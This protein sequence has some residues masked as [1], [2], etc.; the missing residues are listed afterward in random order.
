M[1]ENVTEKIT[2][3]VETD[4]VLEILSKEIY[5]SP[6]ALLRENLQNAYDAVLMRSTV[7]GTDLRQHVIE[8]RVEPLLLTISDDGIGMTESVL[9][10]NFWKA[11]SSGKRTELAKRSGVIGTFGIGAMANFGV[12]T[13][14]TV[15]TRSIESNTT[16]VSVAERSK[17][18]IAK[19]C[20]DLKRLKDDRT[21]GTT[22]IAELDPS[23]PLQEKAA[24]SY[25][26][27]YVGYVP[28]KVLLNGDLISQQ[29]Y[30]EKF[31]DKQPYENISKKDIVAGAYEA[32]VEIYLNTNAQVLAHVTNL[33]IQGS[34]VLGD[35]MLA[36]NGGQ[37]LGLRNYFGLSP[38]PVGGFYQLGGIAN[39]TILQPT[40][41]R[42][43]ISRES[44]EHISTI[45]SMIERAMSE[46]LAELDAADRNPAFLQYIASSGRTDL[47]KRVTIEVLPGNNNVALDQITQF[48]KGRKL[49]Y[50]TGRDQTIL[51]TFAH[52]ESWLLHVSQNNPRKQVQL[53]YIRNVL[54]IEEVPDK[55]T[56]IRKFKATELSLEEASLLARIAATLSDDYLLPNVDISFAEISHGVAVL[57]SKNGDSVEIDLARNSATVAPVLE[58]YR[59]AY[60]VFGGFVKDF[61]RNHL[62]QRISKFVPSSTREGAEAL[63]KLL[64]RNREL[65]RYEESELGDLEPLLGD[66]LSGD[67]SLAQVLVAARSTIRPQTQ[68]VSPKQVG[69]FEQAIPDVVNSPD[70]PEPQ[71]AQEFEPAPPILRTDISCDLKILLTNGKHAQLN[72]FELFLG[73]SD[74]LFKREGDFFRY[75]HT[76]KVIWAGHRVIYIFSAAEGAVTLYYDIELSEPIDHETASGGMF[77][78]T[79][80]ITKNRIFIPVPPPLDSVFRI[81]EG[82][83]EFFVRFD[84]L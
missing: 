9:R 29:S 12:C 76:T 49:F 61:V 14:L 42:E 69:S 31:Q 10:E 64:Q 50:Y 59:S 57:V 5:D 3:E 51:Q 65:Y 79:T 36:Q 70:A 71:E 74:R 4:R 17:L 26:R 35:L 39:L 33:R 46:T 41:G 45:I 27:S 23:S 58:T 60:E 25:L 84:V 47:A 18:S 75:P 53:N 83:K 67:K 19:E 32:N 56:I 7:E 55:A 34:D 43:A 63:A 21:P 81:T 82:P 15:E 66:Y 20:I 11:G 44:I 2:F 78:T 72:N 48:S 54:K 8:V 28:V 52:E 6:L 24:R 13:K 40:A 37:L 62:Y 22:L 38:I 73:L 80:L 16:L 77:P 30:L 1:S 68:R